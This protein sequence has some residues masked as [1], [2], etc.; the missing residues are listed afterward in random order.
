M[1]KLKIS[2]HKNIFYDDV[3]YMVSCGIYKIGK[4][5][6]MLA[7]EIFNVVKHNNKH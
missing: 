6:N 2:K 3:I 7:Q 5:T 1:K 4:L